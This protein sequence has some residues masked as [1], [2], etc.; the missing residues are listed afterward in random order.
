MIRDIVSF[1]VVNLFIAS[2]MAALPAFVAI[3]HDH[4]PAIVAASERNSK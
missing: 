3:I 2:L 4:Q 1:I